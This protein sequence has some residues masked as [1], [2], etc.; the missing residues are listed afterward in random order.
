MN[1]DEC[2]AKMG[3]RNRVGSICVNCNAERTM[4]G[5]RAEREAKAAAKQAT[6]DAAKAAVVLS[7]AAQTVLVTT[8][9]F[10]PDLKIKERCGIV[11]AEVAEGMNAIKDMFA[12]LSGTFG[13][14][15][16]VTQDALRQMREAVLAELK[17]E[18]AELGADAVIAVDLD[19]MEM[20]TKGRFLVLVASG[21]AVKLDKGVGNVAA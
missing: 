17:T 5:V 8:E 1:C 21:T 20:G 12:D 19:Y 9:A 4:V 18:A 6:I 11:T 3:W 2:G 16:G 10:C 14:R 15:S 7:E 13:G